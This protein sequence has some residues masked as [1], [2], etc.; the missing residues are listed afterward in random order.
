MYLIVSIRRRQNGLPGD[1]L[2][3][4]RVHQALNIFLN[5]FSFEERLKVS[6]ISKK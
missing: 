6:D 5:A 2:P 4:M 1:L 3:E